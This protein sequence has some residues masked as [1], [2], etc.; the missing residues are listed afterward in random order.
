MRMQ[1]RPWLLAGL[2]LAG[3]CHQKKGVEARDDALEMLGEAEV[4]R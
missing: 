4:A 3:L 2:T 1:Y